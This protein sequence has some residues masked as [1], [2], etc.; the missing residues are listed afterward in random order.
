MDRARLGELNFG[1]RQEAM[2]FLKRL[3]RREGADCPVCGQGLELLHRK[4]KSSDLD[5]MCR[6]CGRVFRTLAL[7]DE[8][9]EQLPD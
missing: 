2:G 4:A 5:W 7:L 3:W 8:V 6:K 1:S 9:N